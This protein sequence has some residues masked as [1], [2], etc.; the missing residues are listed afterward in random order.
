M[1]VNEPIT[2]KQKMAKKNCTFSGE[3]WPNGII[4]GILIIGQETCENAYSKF[5]SQPLPYTGYLGTAPWKF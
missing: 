5:R 1:R 3:N 4:A 2:L